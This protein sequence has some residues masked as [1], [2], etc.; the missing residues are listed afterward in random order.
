MGVIS[1]S[2]KGSRLAERFAAVAEELNN[3][4]IWR[5]ALHLAAKYEQT[6][7]KVS[8]FCNAFAFLHQLSDCNHESVLL[9]Y[10]EEMLISMLFRRVY[11]LLNE[12][13]SMMSMYSFICR[14]SRTQPRPLPCGRAICMRSDSSSFP[15]LGS[16]AKSITPSGRH[17]LHSCIA[18]QNY[19]T[20]FFFF[21]W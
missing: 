18:C 8:Y 10:D 19:S 14:S 20:I 1:E 4:F 21:F 16:T 7:S 17:I 6:A 13:G 11:A 2:E 9:P 15:S 12:S 5:I 3:T